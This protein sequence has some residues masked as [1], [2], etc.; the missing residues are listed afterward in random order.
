MMKNKK[1]IMYVVVILA[2]VAAG[3][4]MPASWC[5]KAHATGTSS[6]QT[7]AGP[8]LLAARR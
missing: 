7:A 2:A 8:S 5:P 4:W 3:V 6:T 1:V